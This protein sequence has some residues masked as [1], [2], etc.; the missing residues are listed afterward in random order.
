M[1]PFVP[2]QFSMSIIGPIIGSI[3]SL[4]SVLQVVFSS[5]FKSTYKCC[6]AV[7]LPVPR[8]ETPAIIDQANCRYRT[9]SATQHK[10]ALCKTELTGGALAVRDCWFVS[11]QC[12]GTLL[13]HMWSKISSPSLP[14]CQSLEIKIKIN[15]FLSYRRTCICVIPLFYCISQT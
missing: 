14:L 12:N 13:F 1:S 5:L 15:H 11:M 4:R 9:T 6:W 10:G 2:A 7:A 3:S 8:L